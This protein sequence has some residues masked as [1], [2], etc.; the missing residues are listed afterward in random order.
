MIGSPTFQTKFVV[1]HMVHV[2]TLNVMIFRLQIAN[3]TKTSIKP[4]HVEHLVQ[5]F[6]ILVHLLVGKDYEIVASMC[7]AAVQCVVFYSHMGLLVSQYLSKNPKYS[8]LIYSDD[9]MKKIRQ[10][11]EGKDI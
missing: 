3:M 5:A 9:D 1:F 8:L 6:P 4:V 7:A 2:F 11:L 10:T